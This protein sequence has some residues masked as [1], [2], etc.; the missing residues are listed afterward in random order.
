MNTELIV[1][2]LGLA[3]ASTFI[4]TQLVQRIKD[5]FKVRRWLPLA[6][7]SFVISFAVGFLFAIS[8]SSLDYYMACWVGVI[9]YA[10]AEIIYQN[11]KDK[12]GLKSINELEKGCDNNE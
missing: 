8:F 9:T 5:S 3:V 1:Q 6:I 7:V 12:L 11:L 10:G 4:S 2:I